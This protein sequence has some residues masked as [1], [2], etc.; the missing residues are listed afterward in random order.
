MKKYIGTVA[1]HIHILHTILCMLSGLLKL[2]FI[3]T[4]SGNML[5]S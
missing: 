4:Q 1:E 3:D 5:L 2:L